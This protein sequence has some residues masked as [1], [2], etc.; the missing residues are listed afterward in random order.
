MV[1]HDRCVQPP[2]QPCLVA[3]CRSSAHHAPR[4]GRGGQ[5]RKS[6]ET[7]AKE[8]AKLAA[9]LANKYG[10]SGSKLAASIA[11]PS[12]TAA[13]DVVCT[14]ERTADERNSELHA[15]AVSVDDTE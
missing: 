2:P 9:F 15:E 6:A 7:I 10:A 11:G 3:A 12:S 8:K 5:G 4:A 1:P 13:E 14:G